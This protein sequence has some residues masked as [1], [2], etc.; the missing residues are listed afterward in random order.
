MEKSNQQK[1]ALCILCAALCFACMSACVWL[2]G[3]LPT[4]EKAFF[5]NFVA[6]LAAGFIVRRQKLPLTVAK[7][8]RVFVLLR[9]I[10]GTCGLLFNFY[11]IDHLNLAD[12][13]MLNKLSPFFAIIFSYFLLKE[14]VRFVQVLAV[15]GA[16]CGALLIIKPGNGLQVFPAVVGFLGGLGAGAAYTCVRK[17]TMGGV[18]SPVIVLYFS[19]FSCVMC[20]PLIVT[21]FVLP[22][23]RQFLFLLLCG[24]FSAGGQFAITAAYS[25][26]PAKEISVY[27]YSQVVFSAIIGFFLFGQVPDAF[28]IWGYVLI[29]AMAVLNFV[30]HNKFEPRENT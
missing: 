11:A 30:Y 19:L 4:F 14:K 8:S 9:C 29:I 1:G 26:A 3:D 27:D 20:V 17:A 6:A 16:F 15:I 23:A 25:F 13:N 18:P 24:T 7:E 21:N 12:A 2:V 10:F 28:S 22:T 5:R